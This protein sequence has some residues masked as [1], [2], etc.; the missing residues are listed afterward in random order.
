MRRRGRGRPWATG[1]SRLCGVDPRA[2]RRPKQLLHFSSN[3]LSSRFPERNF[4][5]KCVILVCLMSL[6]KPGRFTNQK[7]VY[8]CFLKTRMFGYTK[9]NNDM[10]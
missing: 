6:L 2:P 1:L 7:P 4:F 8:A 9:Q 3:L 5:Q 10:F